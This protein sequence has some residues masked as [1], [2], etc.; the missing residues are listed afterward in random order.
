MQIKVCDD[1]LWQEKYLKY[2]NGLTQLLLS[3]IYVLRKTRVNFS[4]N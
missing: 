2:M 3:I 1:E 4:K